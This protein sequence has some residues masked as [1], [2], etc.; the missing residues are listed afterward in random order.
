[1]KTPLSSIR[2]YVRLLVDGEADD[3]H[4]PEDFQCHQQSGRP[5]AT[6]DRQPAEPGPHRAGVV[7]VNKS[8]L[9]QR[10]CSPR[11][12]VMQ[13]AAGKTDR[14]EAEFSPL[15]LGVLADRDMLLRQRST[16]SPT[17]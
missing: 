1:M 3:E 5:P 13:P 9:S 11:P 16:S 12:L 17:L 15:Y 7:A 6:A 4:T 14:R 8:P 2:A 10:N